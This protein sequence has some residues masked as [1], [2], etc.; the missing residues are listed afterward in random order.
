MLVCITAVCKVIQDYLL[1][2]FLPQAQKHCVQPVVLT[3]SIILK[4]NLNSNRMVGSMNVDI[5]TN[6]SP[7][8]FH[9][10]S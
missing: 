7:F 2:S 9:L 5:I 10:L 3:K 1:C 6:Y 8:L 4:K